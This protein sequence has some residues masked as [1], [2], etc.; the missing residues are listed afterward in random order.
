MAVQCRGIAS[1]LPGDPERHAIRN[2][3]LMSVADPDQHR[4]VL[5]TATE[6]RPALSATNRTGLALNCDSTRMQL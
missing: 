1:N 6:G 4:I 5:F 2:P 3:P